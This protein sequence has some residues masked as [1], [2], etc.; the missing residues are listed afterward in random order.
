MYAQLYPTGLKLTFTHLLPWL[1]WE[2]GESGHPASL[3]QFHLS[4]SAQHLVVV[5]KCLTMGERSPGFEAQ[6]LCLLYPAL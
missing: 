6:A 2:L 4:S 1:G 3:P 5:P